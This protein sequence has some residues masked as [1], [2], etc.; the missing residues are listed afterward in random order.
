MSQDTKN[1]IQRPPAEVVFADEIQ[2]LIEQETGKIPPGWNM[3]PLSVEK[4]ILGDETLGIEKKFVGSRETITRIIISLATNRGAMLVG[5]PGTAKSWLSEL[6][7]AAISGLSTLTI[8]GGAI[9]NIHQLLY[10]WN[11]AII[12]ERGPVPEALIPGPLFSGMKEGKLVRFEEMARCSPSLQNA[13]LSIL[14]ER[15]LVIP[16]LQ[17]EHAT[18]FASEGFNIIGTSNTLDYG[19]GE[20]SAALKRRLN[21]ET[22]RPI[23]KLDDEIGVVMREASRLFAASGIDVAPDTDV[24]AMLVTIFHELRMGQSVD[25]RSTDRLVT[26]AMSTAEAVTVAHAMGVYAYY[27]NQGKMQAESLVEFLIGAALKD[28]ADDRRRMKHYF[29]TEV[30]L[31]KGL[32]WNTVYE[33]RDLL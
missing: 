6:L 28:N 7:T 18:L 10:A 2:R 9:T 19:V 26:T 1:R 31:K 4:F 8:Q 5:E 22:I 27:Y 21:F 15:L 3:S 33:H 11:D 32:A 14:S 24:I 25:G 12:R 30:A 16:E 20:M 29:E 23:R 17:G 13:V